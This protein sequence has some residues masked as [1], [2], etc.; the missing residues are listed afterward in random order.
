MMDSTAHV[1]ISA[2]DLPTVRLALQ[3]AGRAPS[4]HN[5]QPW[6]WEFDGTSLCL[7]RDNDRLLTAADPTGRQLVISCGA[8]LHHVR[9]V[10]AAG[11]WRTDLERV[12]DPGRPDLLARL[13][14]RR[15]ADPPEG[16][17]ARA[18]AIE[19][20]RTD[21]L[22]LAAPPGFEEVVRSARMLASPHEI[23]LDV[24]DDRARPLLAEASREAGAKRRYDVDYQAELHWWTGHSPDREGIP[25]TALPSGAEAV[26]VPVART[27]PTPP[28]SQ[29]RGDIDDHAKLVVLSSAG[30]S[31]T[32]WLHVGEA[33]SA[34]LLECTRAGLATC[35]LTHITEL[36]GARRSLEGLTVCDGV[37][38]VL[39]RVGAAPADLTSAP[40]TP[41]RPVGEI[42][43]VLP[44]MARDM[45]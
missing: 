13:T 18:A 7:Y 45:D 1:A 23:E 19:A 9:T 24:L 12:P 17:M 8:M 42:L 21:R 44:P 38:Q 37:P 14:F 31:L 33:L 10:L 6:R 39:L 29:R 40:P 43:T 5:T 35:A 36:A 20:R 15:W 27:F 28:H 25:R 34:V 2:P 4:I 30:N 26:H 32:D 16:I 22:P 41:R 11:R 3:R